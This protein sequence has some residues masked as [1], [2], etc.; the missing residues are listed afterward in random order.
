MGLYNVELY[1]DENSV[2]TK[3]FSFRTTADNKIANVA[4]TSTEVPYIFIHEIFLT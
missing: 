3:S 2:G 1:F 4:S